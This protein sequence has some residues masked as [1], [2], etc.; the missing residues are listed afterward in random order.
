[1]TNK[2]YNERDQEFL[3]K[4]KHRAKRLLRLIDLDAP[5]VVIAGE[6]Q[7]IRTAMI[8]L[9]AA[10]LYHHEME[11]ERDRI[12]T[13]A[14]FCRN[15]DCTNRIPANSHHHQL[16]PTCQVAEKASDEALQQELCDE[17]ADDHYS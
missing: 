12:L 3:D 2:N 11:W 10:A 13:A 8:G 4:L 17:A 6:V 9:D 15:H 16:C 1:M 7:M 14:G 5:T